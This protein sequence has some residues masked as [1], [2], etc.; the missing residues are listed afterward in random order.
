MLTPE[1][2]PGTKRK[3]S[4][5]QL[6]VVGQ[7]ANGRNMQQ[8]RIIFPSILHAGFFGAAIQLGV[9]HKLRIV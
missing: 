4:H 5:L 9:A 1:E 6:R 8:S 7:I 3:S 2:K